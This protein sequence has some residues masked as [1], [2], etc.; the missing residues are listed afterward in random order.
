MRQIHVERKIG[1][2][3]FFSFVAPCHFFRILKQPARGPRRQEDLMGQ[4]TV[5]RVSVPTILAHVP[6][7]KLFLQRVQVPSVKGAPLESTIYYTIIILY[8]NVIDSSCM[9]LTWT[10]YTKTFD[11]ATS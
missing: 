3:V 11:R 10:L 5:C 7:L 1:I 2:D 4:M 9:L 8:M 6:C